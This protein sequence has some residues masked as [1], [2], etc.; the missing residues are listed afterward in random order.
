[1]CNFFDLPGTGFADDLAHKLGVLRA[2]CQD[3]GRD[4]SAIEKT[5]SSFVDPDGDPARFLAHWPSWPTWYFPRYCQPGT[6][7]GRSYLRP[8][9][10][11]RAGGACHSYRWLAGTGQAHS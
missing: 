1:M 2:H 9:C 10:D 4:Y 5:V 11:D 7:V 8:G 3:A 6:T